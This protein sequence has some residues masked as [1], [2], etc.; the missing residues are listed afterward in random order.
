M[1]AFSCQEG[2]LAIA[3]GEMLMEDIEILDLFGARDE[4]A[5]SETG[6]KYGRYCS[7]IAMRILRNSYDTEECI[8]DTWL[9]AWNS[10]PPARPASLRVYLGK[11]TRN[12]SLNKRRNSSAAKRGGGQEEISVEELGECISSGHEI[13]ENLMKEEL[14]EQLNRFLDGLS[15]DDR[16][17][18]VR[19]YWYCDSMDSIARIYG[20]KESTVRMRLK[21]MRDRL[22]KRLEAEGILV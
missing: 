17:L 15:P 7:S 12:I 14:T 20:L 21:R 18:F 8:N 13:D 10:I 6:L 22:K 19:R 5:I 3:T 16:K 11:L 1:K 9:A 4:R 2:F